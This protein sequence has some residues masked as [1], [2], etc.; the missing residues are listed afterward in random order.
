MK[1][2]FFILCIMMVLTI[3][4]CSTTMEAIEKDMTNLLEHMEIDS[5]SPKSADENQPGA[6]EA[7]AAGSDY[8]GLGT[9]SSRPGLQGKKENYSLTVQ[10]FPG[11]STVKVM[12]IKSRYYP[13]IRLVPGKYDILVEHEGY[14]SYRQWV[15][16]DYDMI[17][18][19][20][21][22][23]KAEASMSKSVD[24]AKQLDASE[25][26]NKAATAA[27]SV[28]QGPTGFPSR[29]AGHYGSV[30]S[31]SFSPD[32]SLLASGSYDS[33]VIVWKMD[34][35]SVVHQLNHGDRVAAVEFSP[36]GNRILSAG[37]D[38][39]IKLWDVNT[40]ELIQ[41][42]SG[43]SSRIHSAVFDLT[44]K[45]IVSGANNELIIWDATTGKIQN[46]I[47]GDEKLYPRFGPI[48][49]IA[50]NPAGRD[51]EGY[52]FA[53]SCLN[54]VA[55]FDPDT[56]QLFKLDDIATPYSLTYSDDGQYIVWGA[57]HHHHKNDFFPRFVS[58]DTKQRDA[59]LS[60]DDEMAKADR[61]FYTGY[62]PGGGRLAMLTYNQAVIYD[63]EKGTVIRKYSG[64]SETAVTDA[65]LSPDGSILAASAQDM[66]MLWKVDRKSF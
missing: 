15:S 26:E 13:G 65:A 5:L 42:L 30:S 21:L 18:K 4:G 48:R 39:M 58:I 41:T 8:Q 64:T 31:L 62:M 20:I 29:L 17:L 50:F 2:I 46:L 25:A 35:G 54:G 45:I 14:K 43:H 51:A 53:F 56:K 33:I 34:D 23:E 61:V 19:V 10:V 1:H 66:I 11:E 44:G 27:V 36:D 60:R 52:E 24:T 7:E 59:M 16:L 38:K 49:A 9:V 47:I 55:L 22:K 12:N 28:A 32:G 37:N 63:I 40:G 6:G 57:R 3:Y